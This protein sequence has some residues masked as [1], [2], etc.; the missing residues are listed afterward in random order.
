MGDYSFSMPDDDM[1]RLW[2]AVFALVHAD[3]SVAEAE[4]EYIEKII[5][6]FSFSA[7]QK[8]IIKKDLKRKEDVAALFGEIEKEEH[9]R[10]FFNIARTIVW[11]DG[12]LHEMEMAAMNEIVNNLGK[13]AEKY[14]KELRWISRKP[15]V[16][17]GHS[18][19]Q[20]EEDVMQIVMEQM[21][22][23]YKEKII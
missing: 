2:R 3:G 17:V 7:K 18:E 22:A 1:F 16:E 9:K 21:T 14:Q 4:R 11:C 20:P 8:R 13:E 5:N 12:Y 15:I 6:I 10:Q 19:N 23:F